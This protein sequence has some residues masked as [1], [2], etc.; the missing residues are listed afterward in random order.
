MPGS[1]SQSGSRPSSRAGV[2]TS[3]RPSS[4]AGTPAGGST[5]VSS[6]EWEGTT[7][8]NDLPEPFH[9]TVKSSNFKKT[10]KGFVRHPSPSYFEEE[11]LTTGKT[12][13]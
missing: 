2:Q 8:P 3:S 7:R 5:D 1:G 11:I 9:S 13:E 4:R 6:L 12:A 10:V